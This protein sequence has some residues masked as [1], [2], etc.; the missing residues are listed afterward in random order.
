M[1][2]RVFSFLLAASGFGVLACGASAEKSDLRAAV[3]SAADSGIDAAP[4]AATSDQVEI[5]SGV[6]N[7]NRDPAVVAVEV[8]QSGLCTGTLISPRLVL[9]ARHCT[10]RTV[11]QVVCPPAGVQ[12]LG[13]RDP[14]TLSI[15]VGDDV[16][17]AHRVARGVAA[18]GAVAWRR[19][20][21]SRARGR[22]RADRR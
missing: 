16:A 5:V 22:L 6:P 3:E 21:R 12:V 18:P 2:R 14:S 20:R 4:P 13:D 10:S 1:V 7:H 11:A 9:T 17:S 15:L 19:A 8:G